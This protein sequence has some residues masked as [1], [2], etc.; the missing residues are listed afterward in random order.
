MSLDSLDDAAFR[1]LNEVDFPVARFSTGLTPRP[2]RGCLP[3]RST[4]SSR[5][6]HNEDGLVDLAR[7][8]RGTGHILRFIEFMDVV[9]PMAGTSRKWSPAGRST[10]GSIGCFR[11]SRSRPSTEGKLPAEPATAT[12]RGD[13]FHFVGDPTIL[14][15]LHAG[16]ALRTRGA[17]QLSLRL[18]GDGSAGRA[19]RRRERRGGRRSHPSG[20]DRSRGS[21][22]R[23]SYARN[24]TGGATRR[25][26]VHRW[27]DRRVR[28]RRARERSGL[29]THGAALAE[30]PFRSGGGKASA[31]EQLAS[32]SAVSARARAPRHR[33]RASAPGGF[34]ESCCMHDAAKKRGRK[35]RDRGGSAAAAAKWPNSRLAGGAGKLPP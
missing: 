4:R 23:A 7:F 14:R 8:F 6:G 5:R 12:A 17:L 30:R 3:S 28:S 24:R 2:R 35:P 10:R 20:L 1:R 19:P 22:L 13:R 18:E 31:T 33:E 26:V 27:V 21:V 34:C 32:S 9:R 16:A 11:S 25:D 15:G 29:A